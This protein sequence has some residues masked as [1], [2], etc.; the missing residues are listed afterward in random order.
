MRGVR[1]KETRRGP[2]GKYKQK[3]RVLPIQK[4][5]GPT[6][7]GVEKGGVFIDNRGLVSN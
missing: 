6:L 4:E 1:D 5:G 2:D 3:R 7:L